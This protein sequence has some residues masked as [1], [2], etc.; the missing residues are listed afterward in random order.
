[1]VLLAP[2]PQRC[3]VVARVAS[4]A[5][6]PI[7][8]FVRPLLDDVVSLR[9]VGL[10]LMRVQTAGRAPVAWTGGTCFDH[11]GRPDGSDMTTSR[12]LG[13]WQVDAHMQMSLSPC[14][15]QDLGVR[16]L[17]SEAEF[18]KIGRRVGAGTVKVAICTTSLT[19]A[20]KK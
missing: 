12:V 1:M 11:Q 3:A 6:G 2:W 4:G 16:G 13:V 5:A 9:H 7:F 18:R 8:F 17:R 20:A 15:A 14:I 10:W 19:T